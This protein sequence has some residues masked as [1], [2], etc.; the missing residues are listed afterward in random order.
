[1]IAFYAKL[2]LSSLAVFLAIDFAWLGFVAR[3][4][5][6][7]HL[8]YLL[9]DQPNWW[10]AGVFYLLFVAALNVFVVLPALQAQSLWRA[11]LLGALFG[12]TTYAT[13]DL[14]NHAT[15]RDWPWIVTAIDLTWGTVLS[16]AVATAGYL[17]GQAI[18]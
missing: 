7:R 1:M 8:G 5:Y 12:L 18:R 11:I 16:A 17:I 13:Y 15:V 6:R 10:A 14:T 2:Y 9:A 4:F 3:G